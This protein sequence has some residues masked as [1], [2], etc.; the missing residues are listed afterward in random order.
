MKKILLTSLIL[1]LVP[2]LVFLP[3]YIFLIHTAVFGA[4]DYSEDI[5]GKWSAFQYYYESE[6]VACNDENYMSITFDGDTIA[7]DGTVLPEVETE[8]TW[9]GGASLSYD[10]GGESFTYLLSFDNNN[11]L[12]IIVDGTSYIILLR[13]SEG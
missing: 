12:K 11:N 1:V 4:K 13:R 3:V 2:T 9:N 7:V 8:F 5:Q 10:A 6:R